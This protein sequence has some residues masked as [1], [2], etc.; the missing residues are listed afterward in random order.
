MTLQNSGDAF[1]RTDAERVVAATEMRH[2]GS[3]PRGVQRPG[4]QQE[5][6][7]VD[8]ETVPASLPY[9]TLVQRHPDYDERFWRK[10]RALYAGGKTLYGDAQLFEE[11]FPRHRNELETVYEERKRRAY[12]IPYAG[13]LIDHLVA[14]LFRQEIEVSLAGEQAEDGTEEEEDLPPWYNAFTQDVSPPGGKVQSLNQLLRDQITCSLICGWTWTLVDLP[15]LRD[16]DGQA[17]QFSDRVA[18]EEAGALD[19]YACAIMPECVIDWEEDGTGELIWALVWTVDRKRDGLAGSRNM[20][21]ERW[22]YYTRSSWARYELR[23]PADKTPNENDSVPLIDS[24]TH[25]AGRVPLVKLAVPDGLWAMSKL[26]GLA[27]EHLNKRAALSWAETQSLLPELYEFLGPDDASG[28]VVAEAAEDPNR[29]TA[30]PRG[31]GFVQIRGGNDKAE[32]VGPDTSPFDHALKSC[33]NLRD[34]MHRVMHKMSLS[35][36]NTAAALKRSGESKAEDRNAEVAIMVYLGKLLRDHAEAVMFMVALMRAEEELATRF[37]ATGMEKYDAQAAAQAVSEAVEIDSLNIESATFRRL[38]RKALCRTILGDEATP[39][40]YAQIDQE[41]EDNIPDEIA[42]LHAAQTAA[43]V[44]L[45]PDG[46]PL[47]TELPDDDEDDD[48]PPA[49]K[50]QKKGG[51]TTMYSSKKK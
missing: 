8:P 24:G 28:A 40:D 35:V 34:E 11:L 36:D 48:A 30:Q 29:A 2:A 39:E 37:E 45:G 38:H 47:E 51:R 49:K 33:N 5:P 3:G 14:G 6:A 43:K 13:E 42:E 21:T 27:R 19:A 41:L 50:P 16:Q 1:T 26:E 10:L 46:Q 32:Y 15:L 25:T 18:Q 23:H 12:Y 44:G 22:T 4:Q 7:P 17:L 20:V 9:K 31:Q